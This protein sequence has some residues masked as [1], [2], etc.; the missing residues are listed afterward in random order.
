MAFGGIFGI[1]SNLVLDFLKQETIQKLVYTFLIL[2]LGFIFSRIST[3]IIKS[4]YRSTKLGNGNLNGERDPL[5]KIVKYFIMSLTIVIALIYL[6]VAILED[7]LFTFELIPFL[8]SLILVLILGIT[9]IEFIIYLLKVL[10]KAVGLVD[11]LELYSNSHILSIMLWVV[12]I[13]LYFVLLE[14]FLRMVG[15][16][17][18]MFSALFGTI[19]YA[20]TFL[21]VILSFFGLRGFVENLYA[22]FYLKNLPLFKVGRQVQYKKYKG[23]ISDINKVATTIKSGKKILWVPNNILMS[24]ELIFED[25]R[26]EIKTLEDIKKHF[27]EQK[28]SYCGPASAQIIL[29]M[30]GYE[31]DQLKIG[32]LCRTK[33]GLGT[34][35]DTMIKVVQRLTKRAVKG[36]WIDYNNISDLNQEISNWLNQGALVIIDYKKNYLFPTAKRAHYSVVVGVEDEELLIVDPSFKTGGVYFVESDRVLNGMNTYSELIKGKR[37]YIVFAKKGTNAFWR[38]QNKLYF[39][40]ITLYKGLSKHIKD[41]L[42]RMT[43]RAAAIKSVLPNNINRFLK[44][45]EKKEK[46]H[47]IWDPKK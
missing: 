38:I 43:K 11:Y 4:I 6:K 46:V 13:L 30:F 3:R 25:T 33:V 21:I 47:R 9:V 42:S 14:I 40:D 20:A 2:A 37:G 17:F 12:R 22:S 45:W 8:V 32:E 27:T 16:Q 18:T 36:V 31:I 10:F 5:F 29:S 19:F 39:S 15:I 24:S 1:T 26:K 44:K 35:P 7:L 23:E 28:P 41:R 34:H